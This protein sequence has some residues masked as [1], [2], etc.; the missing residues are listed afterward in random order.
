M[1]SKK[2]KFMMFLTL[3]LACISA[4]IA[5][6]ADYVDELRACAMVPDR[7]ARF[8]CYE[9]LGRR[10][11]EEQPATEKSSAEMT[12]RPEAAAAPAAKETA[13]NSATL[14]DDLGGSTFEEPSESAKEQY[15]GLLRSCKKSAGDEWYFYFANGQVWK[16]VDSHRLRHRECNF[17]ATITRDRIGYKLQ[18]EG[19]STKVRVT[20]LR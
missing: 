7:E 6:S 1:R 16:Q 20:R 12:A 2:T 17:M 4:S 10:A 5:Q 19:E 13:T 18:R 3:G 14:P 11:L 8:A 9:N 15:Q